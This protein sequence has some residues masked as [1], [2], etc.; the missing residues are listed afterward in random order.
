M[1]FRKQFRLNG[2][3]SCVEDL[4]KIGKHAFAD[5]GDFENFLWFADEVGDAVGMVFDGLRGIA[6]GADAK[7]VGAIELKQIGGFV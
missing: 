6:L 3:L 5:A 7:G 1:I 2:E 4:L